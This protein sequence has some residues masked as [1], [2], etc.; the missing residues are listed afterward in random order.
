[1]IKIT[2]KDLPKVSLN[3]W[4]SGKHWGKRSNLK[5][6]YKIHIK[7]Q[8]SRVFPKDQKYIVTYAFE[9]ESYPL[10]ASN[11]VG[12]LKMIEDVLFEKDDWNIVDIGGITSR[13]GKENKVTIKIEI[14]EKDQ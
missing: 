7:S 11:C 8:C 14:K 6:S 13:K 2:L 12:M 4:Y 1:M 9:F 3:Q 5:K 10:D